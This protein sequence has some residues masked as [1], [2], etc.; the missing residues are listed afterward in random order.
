MSQPQ[1]NKP[2]NYLANPIIVR[3]NKSLSFR[4]FKPLSFG[5]LVRQHTERGQVIQNQVKDVDLHSENNGEPW[6]GFKNRVL[7]S[8]STADLVPRPVSFQGPTNLVNVVRGRAVTT[9][10]N[11]AGRIHPYSIDVCNP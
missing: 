10:H 5:G 1:G 11:M 2:E 3:N 4:F 7:S 6:E 8:I 9:I